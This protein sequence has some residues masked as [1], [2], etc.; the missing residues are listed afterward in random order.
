VILLH[1]ALGTRMQV[2]PEIQIL[3]ARGFGV[4]AYDEPGC[5]ESDGRVTFGP[6]ERAALQAAL[7][8]L[9]RQESDGKIGLYG[10]S[11]GAYI[12]AQV[13]PLE[14][15]VGALVLVG[16]VADFREQTRWDFRR[17]SIL[18]SQ[19]ALL[20]RTRAGW[21]PG[22]ATPLDLIGRFGR[23]L[24]IISGAEDVNVPP[25]HSARL[26]AAAADPKEWWVI[27][28]AG[29]GGYAEAAPL[30]YAPRLAGFYEASLRR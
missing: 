20:A 30:E 6:T 19:P 13:A 29:H 1:G 5:G 9:R 16:S 3:T 25:D 11:Q 18:S 12:A 10:F 7:A 8:W 22:D 14:A 24:L 27:E 15:D 26:Y 21:I 2:V 17:Y 4:L 28:G 23:P